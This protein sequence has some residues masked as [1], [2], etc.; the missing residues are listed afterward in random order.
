MAPAAELSDPDD[1]DFES[2]EITLTNPQD[3]AAESISVDTSGTPISLDPA[4]TDQH[5]ILTGQ[6][7]KAAYQQVL[8]S[9]AYDNTASPP[10]ASDRSVNFTVND[11]DADSNVAT[12]T[13]DVV[14]LNEQPVLDLD[15]AGLAGVDASAS[16]TE[17]GPR[18]DL[19]SA[20]E[21]TDA[22]ELSSSPPKS[23]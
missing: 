15:G 22:D 4:S 20:A 2:A 6:A 11:G 23:R 7:T 12:T 13:V 21:I 9:A 19:A 16:Y 8:R 5:L 17:D 18:A 10:D 3:A 14:R 1:S